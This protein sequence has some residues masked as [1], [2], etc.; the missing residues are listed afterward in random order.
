MYALDMAI[1]YNKCWCCLKIDYIIKYYLRY[2][3]SLLR[4][5]TSIVGGGGQYYVLLLAQSIAV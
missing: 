1:L 4:P 2:L 3:Y 5:F